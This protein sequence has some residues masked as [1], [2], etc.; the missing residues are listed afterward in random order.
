MDNL[1]ERA[2]RVGVDDQL[3]RIIH[4][5]M[6]HDF[7]RRYALALDTLHSQNALAAAALRARE[8]A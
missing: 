8:Y 1:I 7:E 5:S 6:Q 2:E 4:K 3:D